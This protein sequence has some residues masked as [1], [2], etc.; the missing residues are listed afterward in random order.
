MCGISGVLEL[1]R[2]ASGQPWAP[3]ELALANALRDG[4]P[5]RGP[6][7]A[8]AWQ[9]PGVQ[10]GHRR[11]AILDLTPTADQPMVAA[12]GCA[13][14]FN[15]EIYNYVEIRAELQGQGHAFVSTGDTEVL[16]TA[17]RVW[18]LQRTLRQIRGMFAFAFWDERAR[19]LILARDPTGKKPLYIWR[20]GDSFAFASSLWP[21]MG[22]ARA[23]GDALQADPVAVEQFLA[24][25]YIPAPRT[26]WQAVCKLRAG[27]VW[28]LQP[29][30]VE[31]V[32]PVPLPFTAPGEPLGPLTLDRLDGLLQQAVVRRMRSDV[33]VATFLSGG[34]DSSLVTTLAARLSPGMTA[35]TVRTG[36]DQGDELEIARRVARYAG[37]RHEILDIHTADLSLVDQLVRHYGEPFGDSSA[38][39]SWRVAEAAGV[40]SRVVLTGDGGDEVQ[41]GYPRSQLFALRH[42]LHDVGGVPELAQLQQRSQLNGRPAQLWF[43][44]LRVLGQAGTAA[45]AQLD[46]LNN[47]HSSFVPEVRQQLAQHGWQAFVQQR[48]QQARLANQLERFLAFEFQVYLPE[49]LNVKVDVATMGHAVEARAPLLDKDFTDACWQIRAIDRVRPWETKRIIRALLDRHLPKDALLGRKHGFSIPVERWYQDPAMLQQ[50]ADRVRAGMPGLPFLQGDHLA[51]HLLARRTSGREVGPLAFRLWWLASWADQQATVT[52]PT[53]P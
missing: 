5:T 13:L 28:R 38:L 24:C 27:E 18:G 39:P 10:L 4:M 35:F 21:L 50:V 49:D 36:D 25:G 9:R 33:P 19:Q 22:Y 1:G 17:L 30:R 2:I 45:A 43:R 3:Q 42:L 23:R 12:D 52:G 32:D 31:Q 6:D 37:V 20:R 51:D 29:G 34:L 16:L 26:I 15:G 47:L 46:G 8:G 7:G 53:A 40:S 41:G 11:L 48:W 44:A 14:A